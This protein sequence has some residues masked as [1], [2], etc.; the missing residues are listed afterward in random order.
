[1]QEIWKDVKGYEG[2]YQVSNKGNVKSLDRV[3][4]SKNGVSKNLKGKMLAHKKHKGGYLQVVLCQDIN[5]YI[6]RLVAETFIPN[7]ENLHEINHKDENKKNNNVENLEWCTR[8]YNVNYGTGTQRM[9]EKMNY[10]ETTKAMIKANRK[11][12]LQFDKNDN[13]IK[14]WDSINDAERY[15]NNNLTGN[16]SK[17]LNGEI[18]YAFG[19][20]W[21]YA[22]F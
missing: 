5:R 15:I 21:K 16:I 1:M 12:V 22:K 8:K 10:S 17:C 9:V 18:K 3:V 4:I 19:Y 14:R 7:I 13:F 11:P 6:H 2:M 20:K